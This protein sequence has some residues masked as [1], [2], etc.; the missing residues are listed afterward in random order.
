MRNCGLCAT[1]FKLQVFF[2]GFHFGP[3]IAGFQ[4]S[5]YDKRSSKPKKFLCLVIIDKQTHALINNTRMTS[6]TQKPTPSTV[7]AG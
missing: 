3:G 6:V 2:L 7:A 4:F 1:C 5:F